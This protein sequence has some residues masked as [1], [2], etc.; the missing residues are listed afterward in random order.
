MSPKLLDL[1]TH[2]RRMNRIFKQ[3]SMLHANTSKCQPQFNQWCFTRN[4]SIMNGKRKKRNKYNDMAW[5]DE[6]I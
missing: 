3:K 5:W 6:E 2:L 1:T 4:V